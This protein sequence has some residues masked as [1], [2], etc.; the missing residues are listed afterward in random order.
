[1]RGETGRPK[2]GGLSLSRRHSLLLKLDIRIKFSLG[3]RYEN[4]TVSF[5]CYH[6]G[7]FFMAARYQIFRN[8]WPMDC[9]QRVSFLGTRGIAMACLYAR[10]TPLAVELSIL[11]H[12]RGGD[13]RHNRHDVFREVAHWGEGGDLNRYSNSERSNLRFWMSWWHL[14]LRRANH[15]AENRGDGDYPCGNLGRVEMR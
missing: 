3:G 7:R 9:R 2:L 10:D 15:H 8:A 1:M 11:W 5:V 14:L 13:E 4:R 12:D 6:R